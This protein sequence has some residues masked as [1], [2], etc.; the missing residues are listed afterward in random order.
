MISI[1]KKNQV[2]NVVDSIAEVPVV[3][4]VAASVGKAD[5]Q[6]EPVL[7][8]GDNDLRSTS[9][10]CDSDSDSISYSRGSSGSKNSDRSSH[11]SSSSTDDGR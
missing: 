10:D 4:V 7:S 5:G 9:Y 3:A 2:A 6:I 8:D 1:S 11:S